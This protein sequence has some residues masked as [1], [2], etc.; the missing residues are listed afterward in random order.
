VRELPLHVKDTPGLL[1]DTKFDRNG[2][3]DRVSYI[4]EIKGGKQVVTA[5]LP[6]IHPF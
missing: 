1:V 3:P 6:P 5:T 4:V 2:D